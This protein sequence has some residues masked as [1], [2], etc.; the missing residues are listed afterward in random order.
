MSDFRTTP[1]NGSAVQRLRRRPE[2]EGRVAEEEPRSP[3]TVGQAS[4]SFGRFGNRRKLVTYL[5]RSNS[6]PSFITS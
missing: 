1:H 3:A 4:E 2:P 6:R 5:F